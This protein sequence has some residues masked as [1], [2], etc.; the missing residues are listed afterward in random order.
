VVQS[1]HV[2]PRIGG[3]FADIRGFGQSLGHGRNTI[4]LHISSELCADDQSLGLQ[5]IGSE[6]EFFL[7]WPGTYFELF[8]T[9]VTF[10]HQKSEFQK[11]DGAT[12]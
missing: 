10:V 3:D 12:G 9:L 2:V 7:K 6:V 11:S 1:Q 8:T 5:I 4:Q